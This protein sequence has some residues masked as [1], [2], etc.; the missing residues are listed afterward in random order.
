MDAEDAIVVA[1]WPAVIPYL[2]AISLIG[3]SK[4][5]TSQA[6]LDRYLP[7]MSAWRTRLTH[8]A[9]LAF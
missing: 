2:D 5:V 7:P 4:W 8:W 9:R 3:Q 1:K 6:E